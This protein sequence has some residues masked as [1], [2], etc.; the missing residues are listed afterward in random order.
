MVARIEGIRIRTWFTL[1][2]TAALLV[3][4]LGRSAMASVVNGPVTQTEYN[5]SSSSLP[6][7]LV[8]LNNNTSVNYFAQ[9]TS[10]GCSLP[11]NSID[12]IKIFL[13]VA[14]AAQLAG[15]SVNIYYN[16]CGTTLYMYDIVMQ[17]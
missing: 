13:S 6:Q 17:H 7:L 11:A 16:T 3:G 14:Q 9:Q 15:K 5:A 10:P 8:Q 2:L 12:T 1:A 4:G